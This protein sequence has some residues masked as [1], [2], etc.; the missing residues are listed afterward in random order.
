MPSHTSLLPRFEP[1]KLRAG[2]HEVLH[3][4]LLELA[5][6]EN[7]LT[8]HDFVAERLADLCDTERQLHAPRLLHVQVVHEDAL[9]GFRTQVNSG[10]TFGRRTDLGLEHQI[11]LT[12]VGPV[13]RAADGA[14]DTLI[15]DD[16]FQFIQV[17]RI[18]RITVT[19]VQ[20]IAF[21]LM[22]QHAGIGFAELL[23]IKA[24]PELLGRLGYFFV[25]LFFVL[26]NLVF[27]Q[28]IRTITLLAV[29]VVNQRVVECVHVSAG[30]PRRRVHEDG[31]IDAYDVLVQQ[32]HALPPI[33]LDVIFQLHTVLTVIIH[34]TQSVIDVA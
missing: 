9:G 33:L 8:G 25:Y 11:E 5:H 4:H 6:T 12:D 30:L 14:H 13:M 31:G 16:L 7:K 27:N 3:L 24:I 22:F 29:A 18:H 19:L 1:L 2:L 26:G 21:L 32:H 28:Y 34:G 15:Q 17:A 23:L 10:R 20:R